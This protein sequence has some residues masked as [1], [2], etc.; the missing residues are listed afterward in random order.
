MKSFDELG[1]RMKNYERVS[2]LFLITSLPKIIRLDMRSG[3]TFT[4]GF[5][6]PYDSVFAE[7]MTYTTEHLCKNIPGVVMGY[8]Q[9]DEIS[10]IINDICSAH[11][12]F[13]GNVE[14]LVSLSASEATL[15]FNKKFFEMVK[16]NES[17]PKFTIYQRR[18]WKAT[19]DS[20]TFVLPNVVEVHNYLV[21]RQQDATKNSISSLAHTLF[22][23]KEL[24]NKNS[25]NMQDMMMEKYHI[26]WNNY[27]TDFKRGLC[28]IKELYKKVGVDNKGISVETLRSKWTK[29]EIPILTKDLNFVKDIFSGKILYNG[30][31]I[32]K[33]ELS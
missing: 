18:L 11:G 32:L 13:N 30:K 5:E 16:E 20:R 7:C 27:P 9:S 28:Y 31:F 8:S 4:K 23:N 21:W 6:R 3:H 29:Y 17:N 22:S 12:F 15:A 33:E 14:K 19:F 25:S 24:K 10:L 26:N 2:K 1:V